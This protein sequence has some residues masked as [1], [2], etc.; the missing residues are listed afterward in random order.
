MITKHVGKHNSRKIVILYRK[1]PNEDHMALVSYTEVLPRQIHDDLMGAVESAMGQQ[2]KELADYLFRALGNSGDPILTT[3]HKEG[4]IKKVP[5]NQIIVTPNTNSSVRLDELNEIL[6]KM[7]L[8]EEAVKELA[9]LDNSQGMTG[10]KRRNDVE[11]L[12][13]P[14]NSR[15]QPAQVKNTAT[16]NEVLGDDDLASQRLAQ[17]IKMEQEAQQLLAEAKRLKAEAETQNGTPVK[18]AKRTTKKTTKVK[19][20]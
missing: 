19:E 3:L 20:A 4:F 1:V 9:N 16:L 15:S 10:K 18:N 12:R 17:A 7:A 14:A 13:A 8:G 11:E 6:D 2:A 5:T